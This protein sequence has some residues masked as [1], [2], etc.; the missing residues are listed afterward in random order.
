MR[1]SSAPRSCLLLPP[2]ATPLQVHP[3]LSDPDSH[4]LARCP[5]SF[6]ELLHSRTVE[7]HP[8]RRR[9]ARERRARRIPSLCTC[10]SQYSLH[11]LRREFASL[12]FETCLGCT[13][14]LCESGSS[15]TDLVLRALPDFCQ[16]LGADVQ[17]LFA[18]CLLPLKHQ[19]TRLPKPLLILRGSGRSRRNVSLSFL[20]RAFGFRTPL[21]QNPF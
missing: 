6:P 3:L 13:G 19:Q 9:S 5:N 15:L 1:R 16:C 7:T 12:S 14:I 20:G 4:S 21:V 17:R 2:R 10:R 11:D 18:T 8:I